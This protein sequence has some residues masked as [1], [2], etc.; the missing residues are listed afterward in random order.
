MPD[1][2]NNP[3]K[4]GPAPKSQTRE[5]IETLVVALILALAIRNW[6]AEPRYIPSESMIPT[7]LVGDRLIVE[8]VSRYVHPP[9]FGDILVFD[10]PASAHFPTQDVLIKRVIGLPGDRLAV[11]DGRVWRNGAALVEPYE[12]NRPLYRLPDPSDPTAY[13]HAGTE[14]VV[15]PG[16]LYMMGD[17]RNNSA[18]SHIW[19]FLPIKNVVGRAV[20][21]FW[22][23][24]RVGVI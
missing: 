14:I 9:R 5:N 15:P 13:F 6:V 16:D 4:S 8:K 19:G 22:P 3:A 11:H 12:R 10:P 20:F 18:D 1:D 23:P 17:N 2:A 24:N 7:L 21:R